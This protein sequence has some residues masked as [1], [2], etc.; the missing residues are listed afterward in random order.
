MRPLTFLLSALTLLWAAASSAADS[1]PE[2]VRVLAAEIPSILQEFENL[3]A[4]E[5]MTQVLFDASANR[6]ARRRVIVSDY[7]IA[8]LEED[9][10]VLW[11]FRFV[12][13]VDGK[14]IA[15]ADTRMQD[16]LRLRHRDS[17]EERTRITNLGLSR[18]LPGCYWHNLSLILRAFEGENS[19]NFDWTRSGGDTWRFEQVRGLGIPQDLFDPRSPRHYPHGSVSFSGGALSRLDLEWPSDRFVTSVSL[20]FTPRE[21]PANLPRPLKYVAKRRLASSQRA[22]IQTTF[23]YDDY[24]RFSVQSESQTSPGVLP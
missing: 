11:E 10:N 2:P 19:G 1:A 24:R 18:S 21:P 3:V 22:L 7:Q 4:R 17:R 16:F 14:R 15:D 8:P 13:E 12:R 23:E 20:E 6:P 5:R 9:P